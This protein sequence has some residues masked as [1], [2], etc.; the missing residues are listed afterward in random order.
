M[1][2]EAMAIKTIVA[3]RGSAIWSATDVVATG[4][5][6]G[7][8]VFR[9]CVAH[10]LR[11]FRDRFESEARGTE[12]EGAYDAIYIAISIPC[13][14]S[15]APFRVFWRGIAIFLR[16]AA[17][18][19]NE[20]SAG[21][22]VAYAVVSDEDSPWRNDDPGN[23][24]YAEKTAENRN[25]DFDRAYGGGKHIK[26]TSL[27]TIVTTMSQ[28]SANWLSKRGVKIID[29]RAD[30]GV[31][32]MR[33]TG[34]PPR[35]MQGAGIFYRKGGKTKKF[36]KRATVSWLSANR[37]YRL[38]DG[39]LVVG[40]RRVGEVSGEWEEC[41]V[42]M[43]SRGTSEDYMREAWARSGIL[44][45]EDGGVV[46]DK[47]YDMYQYTSY[48]TDVECTCHAYRRLRS[49]E[50]RILLEVVREEERTGEAGY[51]TNKKN[52]TKEKD[53]PVRNSTDLNRRIA[54]AVERTNAPIPVSGRN[55]GWGSGPSQKWTVC[56]I[57]RREARLRR[58]D[59]SSRR[60]TRDT[61]A[62]R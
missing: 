38:V 26:A 32:T 13:A 51:F 44:S 34:R 20:D 9:C 7:G 28:Y 12:N 10:F 55:D 30:A 56:R 47:A 50:R 53:A 11:N 25:R 17:G 33:P 24:T 61:C 45:G 23:S 1:R 27:G 29:G 52:A 54:G 40:S 60:Y 57:T 16:A 48:V 4:W 58:V 6:W 8:V 31:V 43:H 59:R 15:V 36:L 2:G 3:E 46:I 62:Y 39:G 14:W 41:A 35:L 37:A 42:I 49:S 5:G 19:P 22:M 21:R 18:R